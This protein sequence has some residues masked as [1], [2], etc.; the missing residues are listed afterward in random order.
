MLLRLESSIHSWK[1]IKFQLEFT[2]SKDEF[3]F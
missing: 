1:N 3:D 2:D